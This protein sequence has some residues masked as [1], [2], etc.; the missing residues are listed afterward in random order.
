VHVRHPSYRLVT[1]ADAPFPSGTS[2]HEWR[3]TR[4]RHADDVNAEVREAVDQN[5]YSL[6][7]IGLSLPELPK[8]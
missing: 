3:L 5:G 1:N 8:P 4:G 6:F 2:E 7:R